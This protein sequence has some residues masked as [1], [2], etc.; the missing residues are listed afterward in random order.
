MT[1][2]V[3]YWSKLSGQ[4]FSNRCWYPG[5]L[6]NIKN[7]LKIQIRLKTDKYLY[8][9]YYNYIYGWSKIRRVPDCIFALNNEF[10]YL[11]L[12]E[13]W[14]LKIPIIGVTDTNYQNFFI[15]LAI[16]GNDKSID[17]VACYYNIMH[18]TIIVAKYLNIINFQKKK[19][20]LSI[21]MN[22]TLKKKNLEIIYNLKT[23]GKKY[24]S[25]LNDF[26]IE[27]SSETYKHNYLI[28]IKN[29]IYFF[30]I[31]FKVLK[32]RLKTLKTKKKY[33]LGLNKMINTI[34]FYKKLC[35]MY[36]KEYKH[37]KDPKIS[38]SLIKNINKKKEILWTYLNTKKCIKLKKEKI[39][40]IKNRYIWIKSQQNEI[41]AEVYFWKRYKYIYIQLKKELVKLMSFRKLE[42]LEQQNLLKNYL[43][44]YKYKYNTNI[45]NK[46]L[47][48]DSQ[49]LYLHKTISYVYK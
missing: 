14:F 12:K 44:F 24:M 49:R 47:F 35:Q 17:A 4:P 19:K 37:L 7:A 22:K 21:E 41:K 23:K 30:V 20:S 3:E 9:K 45:I 25:K 16:L 18:K 31:C 38:E 15:T 1:N 8:E 42:A 5:L 36:V 48:W 46:N 29:N 28:Y 11:S 39:D 27:E 40:Y 32:Q 26:E 13:A 2:I 10:N 43:I 33:S 34:Y 6:S